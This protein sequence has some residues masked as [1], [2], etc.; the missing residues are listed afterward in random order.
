[1]GAAAVLSVTDAAELLPA[2]TE[3]ART[4][5]RERG[6]I[7]TIPGIGEVVVWADVLAALQNAAEA[8]LIED[9]P[10]G[11]R[12]ARAGLPS[13]VLPSTRRAAR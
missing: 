3:A 6:L 12:R 4:W 13:V 11:R 7:R 5:L 9:P 2:R 10:A 8:R 1:M